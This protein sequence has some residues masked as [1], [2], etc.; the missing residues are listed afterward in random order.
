[1]TEPI[2]VLSFIEGTTVSGPLKP[3]LHFSIA[4]RVGDAR[5]PAVEQALV[6]SRRLPFD[7]GPNLLQQAVAA[8]GI[9]LTTLPERFPGDCR[10]LAALRDLIERTRPDLIESHSYKVHL[11]VWLA[12]RGIPD[13]R[14]PA[15][16]AFH[17][18]Y[19]AESMRVHLYNQL[20]RFTLPR[21]D[22]VMTLCKPF[23]ALLAQRGV[24]AQRIRVIRNAV[25]AL[26]APD[27]VE[28]E[29][30]RKRYGIADDDF[31]ILSVGRLSAEKGHRDLL[32]AFRELHAAR[33]TPNL[34]LLLVGDG[35]ERNSLEAQAAP[36]GDRV[37]FA[38]HHASAFPFFYLAQLFTLPSHSEGSPLV[39]PEAML[40][41]LPIV[42][43]AVGGVPETIEDQV[44]ALLVPPASPPA[45][46][47]ALGR[48][49]ADRA[50]AAR[51]GSAANAAALAYTPDEYR[52]RLVA[53]YGEVLAG[54]ASAG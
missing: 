36:L 18:G 32:E 52:R 17:H 3:M 38:G 37:V 20:D 24:P 25:P 8:A 50:L 4:A 49:A 44:S 34:K 26:P 51:L 19:T 43:T 21:A 2:R 29:A 33:K 10:V 7:G 15:W 31:V 30:L 13:A 53:I 40:A 54:R 5:T 6:T 45:L 41:K 27:P 47:A 39:L 28:V 22:A 11:L 48:V 12:R 23:A 14:R 35:P 42:A 16:I 9:P 46:A 1:M